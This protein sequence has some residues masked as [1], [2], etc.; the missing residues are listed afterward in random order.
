MQ[1]PKFVE[2]I[3]VWE[4]AVTP[5]PPKG[6]KY[7]CYFYLLL[8]KIGLNKNIEVNVYSVNQ[9]LEHTN[10]FT[11]NSEWGILEQ[12]DTLLNS[13]VLCFMRAEFKRGCSWR[14]VFIPRITYNFYNGLCIRSVSH[15]ILL[16]LLQSVRWDLIKNLYK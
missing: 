11:L 5:S 7:R 2:M 10:R 8:K 1:E 12:E 9:I 4:V 3:Y 14:S 15:K 6:R 13:I 16:P